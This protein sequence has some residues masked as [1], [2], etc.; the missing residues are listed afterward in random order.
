MPYIKLTSPQWAPRL[1][2]S[3]DVHGRLTFKVF[4]NAGRYYLA[5]PLTTATSIAS[6]V[7][8]AGQYGT[9]TGINP[10]TGAPIGFTPLPQRPRRA[11]R[12]TANMVSRRTRGYRLRRT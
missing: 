2:F 4:G 12:S 9:Y 8:D 1:G 5:L 3:W 10:A 7:I 11:S 6:P